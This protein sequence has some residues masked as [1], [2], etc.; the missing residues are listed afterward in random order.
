[1]SI[2]GT[3]IITNGSDH[4]PPIHYLHPDIPVAGFLVGG[5]GEELVIRQS[6][7]EQSSTSNFGVQLDQAEQ[8]HL[9]NVEEILLTYRSKAQ[10]QATRAYQLGKWN[11]EKYE[12]YVISA[13][14]IASLS[15]EASTF[16]RSFVI[17]RYGPGKDNYSIVRQDLIHCRL[18]DS[19]LRSK[20]RDIF[21]QH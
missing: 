3:W 12:K 13:I 11:I 15:N 2:F 1:M 14:I 6:H 4:Y 20:H 7:L 8:S 16:L 21:T 10:P 19:V 18:F 9:A 17:I 5:E